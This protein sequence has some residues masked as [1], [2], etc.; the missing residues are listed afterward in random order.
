MKKR[1]T[2]AKQKPKTRKPKRKP[3]RPK[4][5]P[6]LHEMPV[7][8][9][10]EGWRKI[11]AAFAGTRTDA[12]SHGLCYAVRRLIDNWTIANVMRRAIDDELKRVRERNAEHPYLFPLGAKYRASRVAVAE[13]FA[14]EAEAKKR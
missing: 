7:R 10:A 5:H 2:K 13:R 9:A 3:P 8:N 6:A 4:K 11:A 12:T 14:K 1:P